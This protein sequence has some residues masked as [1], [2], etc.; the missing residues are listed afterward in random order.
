[1]ELSLAPLLAYWF[2]SILETNLLRDGEPI[3][4]S[5][6]VDKIITAFSNDKKANKL[7]KNFDSFHED[8]II[9]MESSRSY[10]LPILDFNIKIEENRFTLQSKRNHQIQSFF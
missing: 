10:L 9:T 1:M 5:M 6:Y 3:M 7:N 4:Y 8:L 2:V